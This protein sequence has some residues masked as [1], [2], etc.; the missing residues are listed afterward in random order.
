V[1]RVNDATFQYREEGSPRPLTRREARTRAARQFADWS[2]VTA[3]EGF[4]AMRYGRAGTQIVLAHIN[5]RWPRRLTK[6][7]VVTRPRSTDLIS[8]MH[9]TDPM[10]HRAVV[11]DGYPALLLQWQ[12]HDRPQSHEG[13]PDGEIWHA[14]VP[15]PAA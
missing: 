8:G 13:D 9:L 4:V 7:G 12:H 3:W 2:C 15:I 5:R 6:R 1:K 10:G 14:D 11:L